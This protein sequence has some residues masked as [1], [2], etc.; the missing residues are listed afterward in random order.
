MKRHYFA[1]AA[2]LLAASTLAIQAQQAPNPV[3]AAAQAKATEITTAELFKPSTERTGQDLILLQEHKPFY[4]RL[5]QRVTWTDN[6]FYTGN[7]QDD[8]SYL[9]SVAAGFDTV[10]ESG[11]DL[12]LEGTFS[13][14]R[15]QRFDQLD[16]NYYG[17]LAGIGYRIGGFRIGGDYRPLQFMDRNFDNDLVLYHDFGVSLSYQGAFSA[18]SGYFLSVRGSRV[19]GYPNEYDSWRIAP[20]AGVYYQLKYWFST[21]AGVSGSHTSYD[22]YFQALTGQD[23][24]D[25]LVSGFM[26]VN[27]TP[28]PWLNFGVLVQYAD[29]D[30]S[31]NVSSYKAF[32][33]TPN[34]TLRFRF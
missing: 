20:N 28:K 6:A 32:S 22:N 15:Y 30:S 3:E 10:T 14:S 16:Y 12:Q 17:G 11:V 33:V 13:G 29:N 8:F 4:V 9:T 23:R 5:D 31:L 34:V 2:A 24:A 7:K 25:R 26:N 18:K 1:G 19:F 27:F 21:T